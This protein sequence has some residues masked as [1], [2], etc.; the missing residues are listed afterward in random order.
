MK[1]LIIANWKCNPSTL[2]EAKL[3]FN[4]LKR[5]LKKLRNIEVVI[6]PPFLYLSSFKFR[7]PS[8]KLGAQDVFWE[9]RG[10]YTGEISLLMLKNIGVKYV[11]IGHSER[12]RILR[13]TDEMINKKIKATLNNKLKPILCI[14]ETE[15]ERK[16]GKTFKILEN[17]IKKALFQIPK[18]KVRI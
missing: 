17:Q 14:G 12:R 16:E 10:A 15:E 5:G 9:E 2:R 6:C 7:V 1:S 3:L 4:S 18:S 13:E 8:F 11:I